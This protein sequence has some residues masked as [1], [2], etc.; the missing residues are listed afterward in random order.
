MKEKLLLFAL[1]LLFANSV[2][3]AQVKKTLL[4]DSL[5][6][7]YYHQRATLFK[8]LPQTKGDIIFLGNSITDGGE[9]S[10]MF[11]DLRI[12]NRGISG[13]V[14]AG[15]IHRIDEITARR[16]SKVFLLIGT[17]D[18]ARG[19]KPDSVLKYIF[20]IAD[21][22]KQESP[23]TKLYIQSILPVNND[24]GKFSGHMS[25]AEEARKVN[26]SL[27]KNASRHHY[28]FINLYPSFI[29][30]AGKLNARYTNDGLHLTGEGY[31]LW[32]HLVFPY[33]Y[34]ATQQA[35]LIPLPQSVVWNN[36]M[37]PLYAC[38]TILVKDKALYKEAL[39]L[40]NELKQKGFTVNI[41]EKA[42]NADH[43]IELK[44][45][46]VDAPMPA[47]AY[48]LQV[49]ESKVVLAANTPHGIFNGLQTLYQLMRSGVMLDGCDIKDWPQ[50][51]W[52]GYMV[53]VGRNYQSL[54]L[55]KQQIDVMARYRLNV[56]HFHPTE[57][58]AWRIAIRRYPQLTAPK[59]MLRDKGLYYSEADIKELIAYCKE[60]YITFL[61]EIDM[62]GHSDAFT[63]A[64]SFNMQSD[65][66]LAVV[67]NILK[68]FCATYDLPYLHIGGDEVKI[69]NK[70]FL[71]EVI[72]LIHSLGIKTIGWEPGGNLHKNTIRQLWMKDGVKDTSLTYIESR[73]LYLN[74]MDPLESVTTIFHRQIGD[75]IKE[76]KNLPGATLCLWH[77]R[78]VAKEDDVLKLNPV[79]PG[80]LAFAERSWRGGGYPNWITNPG[81]QNALNEFSQ[82]EHRLMDH[83]RQ[84]FQNIPFPYARQSEIT[85]KL[86]GPYQNAGD[87]SKSFEPESR[88]FND[89]KTKPAQQAVGGTVVLR[90]WFYPLVQAVL[91]NPEDSSTWYAT[92]KIWNDE[93]GYKDFWIGFNNLSRSPATDSPT[94]GKWDEKGSTVWVN[95][96]LIEPPVWK[97]GGQSGDL[98]IPLQDEGYEYRE[99]TKIYLEKGWNNV[100]IKVPVGTFKGPNWHNP[101]KWMF[102]FIPID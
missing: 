78:R 17:N 65:S 90:H 34:N 56:F 23:S 92:T 4:H 54:E 45:D 95:G 83:H 35:A 46:Q 63:R 70:N 14:T 100:L 98:E 71:P 99:P 36:T 53:D 96:K 48:R 2:L 32:Q 22:L 9:W 102:T 5:F 85:W 7:T 31:L 52:R 93:A 39:W 26:E 84:S 79:Y 68:E 91:K 19:I 62:P 50:F 81:Q 27:D 41:V 13:D 86:Y 33:V 80:I 73:H 40:Q 11:S 28:T 76:D 18:L 47:E 82:F 43:E 69:T 25:K 66:G 6:S 30:D 51:S 72:A 57:D 60:R 38:K 1:P 59:N 37:F 89:R 20:W 64:F 44:L 101:V 15:I 8:S 88:S 67:K 61:P 74:H 97:R 58:I 21:Y 29:E 3:F 75:R 42:G 10:E 12:K 77:D 87:L 55:L 24:F 94:A 16:P 49:K